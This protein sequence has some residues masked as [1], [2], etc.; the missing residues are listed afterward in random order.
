[1]KKTTQTYKMSKPL[2][3]VLALTKFKSKAHKASFKAAMID[4]ELASKFQPSKQAD[5]KN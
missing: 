2:K 4:A 5:N 3:R 1:M